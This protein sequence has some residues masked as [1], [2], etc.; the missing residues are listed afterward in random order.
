MHRPKTTSWLVSIAKVCS[1]LAFFVLRYLLRYRYQTIQRNLK[2]ALPHKSEQRIARLVIVYYR[3]LSDLCVEPFLFALASRRL[4][5]RLVCFS[6]TGLFQQLFHQQKQ[7]V[8]LASHYGNWEYLIELPAHV[9]YP[10]Y[11]AY[12]PIRNRWLNQLVLDLRRRF[13]VHLIVQQNFYRQALGLLNSADDPKLLVFI[14]DQRPGPGSLKH[15]L[16]F[17][18]QLTYVQPGAER[19]ARQTGAAVVVAECRKTDRFCYEYRFHLIYQDATHTPPLAITQ[20]YY[21]SLEQQIYQSPAYWLWSHDR[22]KHPVV[23]QQRVEA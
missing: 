7:T 19:L 16:S 20:A 23:E 6:D 22:W 8:V 3:H 2:A 5:N 4:R 18:H 10:V 21:Q 13:G 14:A 15:Y 17:L 1:Y 12:S 11:T 9:P